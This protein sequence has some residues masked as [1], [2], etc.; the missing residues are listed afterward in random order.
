MSLR[1]VCIPIVALAYA[2][3]HFVGINLRYIF[4]RSS[5][6]IIKKM[7]LWDTMRGNFGGI[8]PS[9]TLFGGRSSYDI[10]KK[11]YE[12]PL[13]TPK[14]PYTV[15]YSVWQIGGGGFYTTLGFA[16]DSETTATVEVRQLLP[17]IRAGRRYA[18][19][20]CWRT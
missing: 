6:D 1:R 20:L 9:I 11:I 2:G 17:R 3:F 13:P 14:L 18:L 19:G 15:R 8:N 10:I 4:S 16:A 12:I 5:Y 7:S